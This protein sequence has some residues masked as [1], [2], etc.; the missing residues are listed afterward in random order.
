MGGERYRVTPLGRADDTYDADGRQILNY[1]QAARKALAMLD[2]STS[3][4]NIPDK[5]HSFAARGIVPTCFLYRHYDAQGDL[6]Y[7]GMSLNVL[8]RQ[9]RHIERAAWANTIYQIVIEPFATRE[10]LL[11][12]EEYAIRTEFPKH[13]FTHNGRL[14]VLQETQP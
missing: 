5:W 13:N 2:A 1:E 9:V 4:S 12:A 14:H 6:L 11:A 8:A 10:E 7:I 3:A